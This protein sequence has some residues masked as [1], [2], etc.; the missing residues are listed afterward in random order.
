MRQRTMRF[1]PPTLA[2]VQAYA[3]EKG[4]T[5]DALRFT[6]FYASKGWKVGTTPMKDWQAA[7]RNW[8]A[9]DSAPSQP[10][11]AA[12]KTVREQAY[13]QRDYSD[14]DNALPAWMVEKMRE[15]EAP[16]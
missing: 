2:D 5:I 1:R 7:V 11:R 14:E 6:D 15:L 3:A 12:P 16:A 9:R 10:A 13:S 4:L 8:C